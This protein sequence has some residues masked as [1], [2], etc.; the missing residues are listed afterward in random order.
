MKRLHLPRF[1]VI[2]SLTL[3]IVLWLQNGVSAQTKVILK[4]DDLGCI[5]HVCQASPVMNDLMNRKIK[6]AFGII[7]NRLDKTSTAYFEPFLKAT[8]DKGQKLFEIWHHGLDH[9]SKNPPN[10]NRE[11]EGTTFEFQTEHFQQAD[12]LVQNYLGVQMHT[13]GA[14]YNATDSNTVKVI[15]N[16]P[17]Y[18]VLLF[19]GSKSGMKN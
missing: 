16:H 5:N 17:A 13:F 7:A 18:K 9:S 8:N 12:L 4:L 10:D 3:I 1:S 6:A 14:P 11:F 15:S 19:C 2:S